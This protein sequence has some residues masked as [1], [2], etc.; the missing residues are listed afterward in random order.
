MENKNPQSEPLCYAPFFHMFYKGDSRNSD[1]R[2]CCETRNTKNTKGLEFESYND[3]WNSEYIV[4]LRQQML[5][6]EVPELCKNCIFVENNLGYKARDYYKSVYK[7]LTNGQDLK[8]S[9]ETGNEFNAPIGLDY[10]GSNLCNLKC[11]MC[12]PVSSSEIAKEIVNNKEEYVNTFKNSDADKFWNGFSQNPNSVDNF[13]YKNN[14]E[15]NMFIEQVPFD[16]L[17]RIK[18]LGGEPLLQPEVYDALKKLANTPQA[19][20]SEVVF[21]TNGTIYP[22]NFKQIISKFKR[23]QIMISLDGVGEDY[24]Y[25]R[26]KSNWNKTKK[27]IESFLKLTTECSNVIIKVSYVLQMYNI[28]N[29]HKIVNFNKWL[30]SRGVEALYAHVEE[31]WLSTTFLT[32]S[33]REKVIEKLKTIDKGAMAQIQNIL[34]FDKN[35]KIKNKDNLLKTFKDYTNLQ[36]KIRKSSLVDLNKKYRKYIK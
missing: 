8:L 1:I 21:T 16:N 6:N 30:S 29:V 24:E 22:K 34:N 13:L 27:N 17:K 11:R 4:N 35:R 26:S 3:Y 23:V 15:T 28:L 7:K 9:A 33:D 18:L 36:D 19:N 14:K 20:Q 25:V 5:D 32:D 10:R 31:P 2:P 12:K